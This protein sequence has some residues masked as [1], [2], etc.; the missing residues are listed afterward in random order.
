MTSSF[1]Y[2]I[3]QYLQGKASDA[4][5]LH[6]LQR[7]S[8]RELAEFIMDAICRGWISNF[9]MGLDDGGKVI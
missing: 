1:Q 2:I 8:K 4:T 5:T 3:S 9:N 6:L 7:L